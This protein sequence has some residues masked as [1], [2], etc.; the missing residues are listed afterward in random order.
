MIYFYFLAHC[1]QIEKKNYFNIKDFSNK[2]NFTD[3]KPSAFRA[4]LKFI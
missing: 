3:T 2:N 1:D 4:N